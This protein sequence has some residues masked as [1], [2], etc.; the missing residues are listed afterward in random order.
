MPSIASVPGTP[1]QWVA[2][3]LVPTP[4]EFETLDEHHPT[5]P[6]GTAVFQ[7][8]LYAHNTLPL[9]LTQPCS[10]NARPSLK[11][12][13]MIVANIRDESKA[14]R[15]ASAPIAGNQSSIDTTAST[16]NG[17]TITESRSAPPPK[18]SVGRWKSQPPGQSWRA[19]SQRKL[20]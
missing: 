15:L 12:V 11:T 17:K 16:S 8:G 14:L 10:E 9:P 6:H 1:K 18:K 7:S 2:M 3:P 4:V 13:P 19:E 5:S 20:E